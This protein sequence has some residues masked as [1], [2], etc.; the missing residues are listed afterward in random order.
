M[1]LESLEVD[2]PIFINDIVCSYYQRLWSKCKRLKYIQ[3]FWLSNG[4]VKKLMEN[5]KPNTIN[6]YY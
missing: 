4:S 2:D 3:T 5:P 6:Q 1:K